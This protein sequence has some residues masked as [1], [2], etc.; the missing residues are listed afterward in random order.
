MHS[1]YIK[2]GTNLVLY[3]CVL[4]LL[5]TAGLLTACTT[6]AI[7]EP[8]AVVDKQPDDT[9][10]LMPAPPPEPPPEPEPEP[11]E[12]PELP[13]EPEPP[14]EPPRI[15]TASPIRMQIPVLSL[16]YEIQMTDSDE[17]GNMQI[18][19]VLDKISWFDLG[20]IPGNEGNAIFG[21]HNIWRGTRSQLYDLDEM[22]VGDV[23]II[24]YDDETSLMFLLE[25]VFVYPL[26]T[27]PAY[28]IMAVDTE[29][30]VTLITCK[31]PFNPSIGTSDNRI[32]ATFREE[33][34]F[35]VPDP[36]VEPFPPLELE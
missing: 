26:K 18:L 8:Q 10:P 32:V 34:V 11:P 20:A 5:L 7:Q 24:D 19:P 9:G 30:R 17:K 27:A 12:E 15:I 6:Q 4:V 2:Y 23:M 14:E 36:P 21:G 3:I 22:E 13:E 25:S 33:D 35:V 1:R 29:P 16:D 28:L 31:P